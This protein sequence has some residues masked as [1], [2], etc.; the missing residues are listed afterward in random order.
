MPCRRF[1]ACQNK[2]NPPE[3]ISGGRDILFSF[4]AEPRLLRLELRHFP[5]GD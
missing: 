2:M 5:F 1:A 4:V 3:I